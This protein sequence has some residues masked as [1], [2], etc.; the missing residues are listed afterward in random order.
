[1]VYLH[2]YCMS[3]SRV[4]F[5]KELSMSIR[6][7]PATEVSTRSEDMVWTILPRVGGS[8]FQRRN[9]VYSLVESIFRQSTAL[10][11]EL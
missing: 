7:V 10:V 5:I 6:T 9:R 1:M 3:R 11:S 8:P 2:V 4:L